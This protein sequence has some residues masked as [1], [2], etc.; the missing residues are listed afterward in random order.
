LTDVEHEPAVT[1]PEVARSAGEL[2]RARMIAARG[3]GAGR[4]QQALD[5]V[6]SD[7][8][9]RG[10]GARA[11]A[12]ALRDQG[13]DR[14]QPVLRLQRREL[15]GTIPGRERRVALARSEPGPR[16]RVVMLG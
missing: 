12:I 13:A 9:R 11:L 16:K 1:G 3:G 5:V 7:G 4:D 14:R 6:R 2:D 10:A 8:D 15:G